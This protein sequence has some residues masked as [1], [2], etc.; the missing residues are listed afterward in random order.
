MILGA[1]PPK[2]APGWGRSW[3]WEMARSRPTTKQR[4]EVIGTDIES[5]FENEKSKQ[6]GPRGL[7]VLFSYG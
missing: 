4:L 3:I 5:I 1:N 7:H 6:M 2:A